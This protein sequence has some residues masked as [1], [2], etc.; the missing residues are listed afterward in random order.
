MRPVADRVGWIGQTYGKVFLFFQLNEHAQL[1][2]RLA[3]LYL[4]GHFFSCSFK[5]LC[6]CHVFISIGALLILARIDRVYL[7]TFAPFQNVAEAEGFQL[8]E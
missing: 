7:L 2:A 8:A 1:S 6:L 4:P 5:H 3:F